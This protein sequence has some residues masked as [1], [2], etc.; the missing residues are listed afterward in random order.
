MVQPEVVCVQ[1]TETTHKMWNEKRGSEACTS[2]LI[3]SHITLLHT[4]IYLSWCWHS[5]GH[6]FTSTKALKA[7]GKI[8]SLGDLFH[9]AMG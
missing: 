4:P 9:I 6:L 1:D 8:I 5:S 3:S 2:T 7:R